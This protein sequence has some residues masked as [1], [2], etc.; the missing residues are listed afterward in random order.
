MS[1]SIKPKSIKY[2]ETARGVAFTADLLENGGKVGIVKLN[3]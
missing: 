2:L 3:K 1:F